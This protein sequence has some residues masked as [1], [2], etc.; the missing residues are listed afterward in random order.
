[1]PG[2]GHGT[3]GELKKIL[4]NGP[5]GD[6]LNI[7]L[8]AEGF[9]ADQQ[10]KFNQYCDEF[11]T[12]FKNEPWYPVLGNAFNIYR[13]N[14]AS[15]M[16]G[17]DKPPTCPDPDT[18]PHAPQDVETYFDAHFCGDFFT[19]RCLV[20][21]WYFMHDVLEARVPGFDAGYALVN[22]DVNNIDERGGCA[23][24]DKKVAAG[25]ITGHTPDEWKHVAL[26]EIGHIIGGLA[27][28]YDIGKG[29]NTSFDPGKPNVTTETNI[30][31]LKWKD[32]VAPELISEHLIPTMTSNDCSKSNKDTPNILTDDHKIGLFEGA[33]YYHCGIYRPAFACRMRRILNPDSKLPEPFCRVCIQAIVDTLVESGFITPSPRMEVVTGNGTLLLDFG[34]VV[35]GLT[36]YRY[37]EVRNN[38]NGSPGKLRVNLSAAPTG[39]FSYAPDTETSFTLP[40]P[41]LEPYTF[42]KIFVSFTSSNVGGPDFT[43]SLDVT[44]P[45]DPIN[46]LVTVDLLAKAKPPAPVDSVLIFDRSGSMIED[47]GIP[48][49]RKID[50]AIDAGKLF[51]SLLKD[52]DR[53]GIVRFNDFA[54][55]PVDK[56][57]N[58]EVAGDP[59][60]GRVSAT[61]ALTTAN[62]S[63]SGNTS[64]GAGII[65]GSSVLDSAVANSRALI[66][67]T[68]GRQNTDPDIPFATDK[69]LMKSPRQRVFAIGLG[70]NQLEDKLVQIASVTNGVAQITGDLVGYKEFLL[71]KLY[72]QILSDIS[73]EA[74][75]K[76]PV[77]IVVAGQKR[78][79]EVYIGEIDIS[80]DFIIVFRKTP[81]F[82]K[83]SR[84]WLEA[85][86]G[87]IVT[88]SDTVL[89]P[90]VDYVEA[91]SHALF[92]WVFPAFPDRPKAHIGRWRVWVENFYNKS[93]HSS[94]SGT[95]NYAV[96]CKVRSDLRLPGHLIQSSYEPG[97]TMT[98]ILEPT[99]FG[100]PLQL[101]LP[102]TV[103]IIRPDNVVRSIILSPGSYGEYVGKFTDTS[104]V[105]PYLFSTEVSAT[106]PAGNH[107]T[108]SRQFTG[109]IF[110]PRKI[111][112]DRISGGGSVHNHGKGVDKDD[113][114]KTAK[115][116][117]RQLSEIIE[118]CC[119]SNAEQEKIK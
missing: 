3:V 104:L 13:L 108:R 42:R 53:I 10:E 64:I 115:D 119:E 4:D 67:L 43:G 117:I 35:Y 40:S 75:A 86:D 12:T 16:E 100:Q 44:T 71:H 72:V 18:P 73:D 28:E 98:V 61:S 102:P 84:F 82:P 107:V 93:S 50:M 94:D 19:W 17:A 57:L 9:K 14:V 89:M 97:S 51:V 111:D 92:R 85:P 15:D 95:F 5:D 22:T 78:A 8:V 29:D 99:V 63:P 87:T 109:L 47:T 6:C 2:T 59:D 66:V 54:N 31:N 118:R 116:L 79:T 7:V 112:K 34:E 37:F 106:S 113:D 105:G 20:V 30:M 1:M 32:F 26:H 103:Q 68:D 62:L 88:P 56:L 23:N 60:N 55:D 70:L 49:K 36:M 33:N 81:V 41:V 39:Q 74:F 76:D 96:M 77:G 24:Y 65:L 110:Y 25:S 46:P 45:D 21:E 58:L 27:D 114:C 11:V 80:A 101:D 91:K 48:G 90:N 38:R 69:V 52:N 83:S